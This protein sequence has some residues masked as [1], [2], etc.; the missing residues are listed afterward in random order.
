MRYVCKI[1]DK[2][3]K[4]KFLLGLL[5]VCLTDEEIAKKREKEKQPLDKQEIYDP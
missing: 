5:H 3:V 2:L 4:D 1:C